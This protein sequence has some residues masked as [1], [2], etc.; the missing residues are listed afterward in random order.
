MSDYFGKDYSN[1][2]SGSCVC[3]SLRTYGQIGI[4][5]LKFIAEI[6]LS[7]LV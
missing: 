4:P 3:R 6:L 2:D 5:M 1:L 7:F